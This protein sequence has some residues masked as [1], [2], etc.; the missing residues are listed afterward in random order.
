MNEPVLD[1]RHIIDVLREENSECYVSW[2]KVKLYDIG[3][4]EFQSFARQDLED[5]S[6]RGRINALSNAKRA[7][8]CRVDELL[9]L[10]NFRPFSSLRRWG[11]P[12]KMQVIKTFGV[13]APDVLTNYISSKRNLLEHE[14][15]RSKSPE[16]TRHLADITELFL[17]ATDG[18]VEKGH[19]SSATI[20][21]TR[22]KGEWQKSGRVD[23]RTEY[24]DRYELSFDLKEEVLAFN[25]R[26][27]ELFSELDRRTAEIRS[28]EK[29]ILEQ[30][31]GAMAI[32]DF[33]EAD[34]RDLMNALR[35]KAGK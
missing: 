19:I 28:R 15:T 14:Y 34:V 12:Y 9:T 27:L 21:Y 25:Y 20:H 3:P 6:E 22:E 1:L 7:I 5:D 2:Q 4:W 23:T 24:E 29:A 16:E 35:E 30:S 26:R 33:K 18:H 13:S 32:R 17:S 10:F 8:E 31:D 11:L